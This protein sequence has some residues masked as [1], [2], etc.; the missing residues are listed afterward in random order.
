MAAMPKQRAIRKFTFDLDLD[1]DDAVRDSYT[2]VPPDPRPME[3]TRL[4][5]AVAAAQEQAEA[6]AAAEAEAAAQAEA[7]EQ[8]QAEQDPEPEPEPEEPPAPTFSEQDLEAARDEA[9]VAGHTAALQ[10]AEAAT[11][12]LMAESLHFIAQQLRQMAGTIDEPYQ[13]LEPM[14]AEIAVAVCRRVLPIIAARHGVEEIEA[15]VRRVVPTVIDQP[16]LVVRVHPA[17]AEQTRSAIRPVVE[18]AGFEGKLV[19]ADDPQIQPGD[20]RMEWGDGGVEKDTGRTWSEVL[21][22]IDRN[23]IGESGLAGDFAEAERAAEEAFPRLKEEALAEAEQAAMDRAKDRACEQ[24]EAEVAAREA[25]GAYDAPAP[26]ADG[27]DGQSEPETEEDA[28]ASTATGEEAEAPEARN[29]TD[30]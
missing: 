24:A 29:G 22:I 12:R 15:L 19:V 20:A 7:A 10:E 26:D 11:E 23:V 25:E 27:G 8:D 9:Y 21:E 6:D 1:G 14:A 4:D 17:L 5:D 16:R 30:G 13:R 28:D 3:D 18:D 2:T